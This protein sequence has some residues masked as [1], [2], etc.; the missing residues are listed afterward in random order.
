[1]ERKVSTFLRRWLGL[2][3]SLSNIALYGN[4]TKLRLPLKSLEEEFKV[5][6][7]RE[8]LM[9]R[10][11]RDPKVAQAGVEVKTG[12]K[13]SAQVA[14]ADAESRLRHRDLVGVVAHGRAGLGMFPTPPRHREAQGKEK[15]RQIQEC[16]RTAVEDG[17]KSRA[18]GL[19]QQGAWTR[20][21]HAMDRKGTWTDL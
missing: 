21:E 20:W 4:T 14:V 6:R 9:Y 17:R 16:V 10:D 18:A 7:T 1:M 19:G 8:V 13:W 3:R 5:T 12:R 11:S 15:R 2:P